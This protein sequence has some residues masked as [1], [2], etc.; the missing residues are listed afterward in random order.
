MNT[1]RAIMK[2]VD[3]LTNEVALL[4]IQNKELKLAVK[5]INDRPILTPIKQQKHIT[6]D[7][8]AIIVS[9]KINNI[10]QIKQV[11]KLDIDELVAKKIASIKPKKCITAGEVAAI[12]DNKISKIKQ[13][14]TLTSDDVIFNIKKVVNLDYVN[15][16]YRK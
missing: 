4:K 13:P 15:N 9:D 11:S 14:N 3:A 6:A 5:S 8:V 10:K 2:K 1:L 16:L 7:D 12:V